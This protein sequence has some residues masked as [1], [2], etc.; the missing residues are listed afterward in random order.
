[1]RG[2][3]GIVFNDYDTT[4]GARRKSASEFA[5]K[6]LLPALAAVGKCRV[7][8]DNGKCERSFGYWRLVT[9]AMAVESAAAPTDDSRSFDDPNVPVEDYGQIKGRLS[10]PQ[11]HAVLEP[12]CMTL[13]REAKRLKWSVEQLQR[14]LHDAEIL[15]EAAKSNSNPIAA[16]AAPSTVASSTVE[17]GA[18]RPLLL[19]DSG[20]T[21]MLECRTTRYSRIS[22]D[23]TTTSVPSVSFIHMP[24]DKHAQSWCHRH[25]VRLRQKYGY[26]RVKPAEHHSDGKTMMG[27]TMQAYNEAYRSC[28]EHID[29]LRDDMK[30]VSGE[31]FLKDFTTDDV[32]LLRAAI[33]IT[34]SEGSAAQRQEAAKSFCGELLF[35]ALAEASRCSVRVEGSDTRSAVVEVEY[36]I[37][38]LGHIKGELRIDRAPRQGEVVAAIA[39]ET[40]RLQTDVK[41]L[42][43]EERTHG[44]LGSSTPVPATPLSTPLGKRSPADRKRHSMSVVNPNR[45]LINPRKRSKGL[46]FDDDVDVQGSPSYSV[47]EL[48]RKWLLP[49]SIVH[50]V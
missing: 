40:S 32:L 45:R 27:P 4:V 19:P 9:A 3:V 39:A 10:L 17:G 12:L 24:L 11:A 13:A 6:S 47:F 1:M 26:C 34:G 44:S 46:D 18:K 15:L 7:S 42:K 8:V 23:Y 35:P 48:C 28:L 30:N 14:K 5:T 37:S 2:V 33:G 21:P 38:D 22:A 43:A 41:Q 49:T 16:A 25:A 36:A 50:S 31:E 20:G 29:R